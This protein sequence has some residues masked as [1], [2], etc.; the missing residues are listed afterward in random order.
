MYSLTIQ[1]HHVKVSAKSNE[2]RINYDFFCHLA[3][4]LE[5]TKAATVARSNRKTRTKHCTTFRSKNPRITPWELRIEWEHLF[6]T[7]RRWFRRKNDLDGIQKR[8]N[9]EPII[10][11]GRLNFTQRCR[12]HV[13]FEKAFLWIIRALEASKWSSITFLYLTNV[14][15]SISERFGPN[16]WAN[17][18]SP[19]RH[20]PL[21]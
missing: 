19:W 4:L 10:Y 20:P 21:R 2:T 5:S 13:Q 18:H 17:K 11:S 16:F 3:L 8:R 12:R 15:T 6:Q 7:F 14:L 9:E 1:L